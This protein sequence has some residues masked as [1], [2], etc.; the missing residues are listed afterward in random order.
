[1]Y[2]RD[3][4]KQLSKNNISAAAINSEFVNSLVYIITVFLTNI[5]PQVSWN[6]QYENKF[7]SL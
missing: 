7:S 3:K 1:M 5:F 2:L 4:N 6:N